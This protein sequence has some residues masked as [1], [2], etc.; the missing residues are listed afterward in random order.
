M[1][2]V[3]SNDANR[4][5][6]IQ[7]SCMRIGVVFSRKL[8]ID[9]ERCLDTIGNIENRYF[10]TDNSSD[11]FPGLVYEKVL[12]LTQAHE[13]CRNMEKF[14]WMQYPKALG[15]ESLFEFKDTES[16][17][18]RGIDIEGFEGDTFPL[19]RIWMMIQGLHIME[20]IR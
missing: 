12:L 5:K 7:I 2:D 15:F 8:T 6:I 11:E 13:F 1:P 3:I 20:P 14:F 10:W 4:K 16:V 18:N 17:G 19:G 9:T